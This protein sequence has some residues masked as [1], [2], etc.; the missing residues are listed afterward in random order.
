MNRVNSGFGLYALLAG[1]IILLTKIPVET[2][3]FLL[4]SPTLKINRNPASRLSISED[5]PGK[6]VQLTPVLLSISI[7]N[8]F[9]PV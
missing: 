9:N 8:H 1:L 2:R 3:C 5:I 4:T 7:R 6:N